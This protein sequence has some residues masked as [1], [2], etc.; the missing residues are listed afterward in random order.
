MKYAHEYATLI[1]FILT[2][3]VFKFFHWITTRDLHGKKESEALN[4]IFKNHK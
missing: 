1:L 3:S 2:I 4:K